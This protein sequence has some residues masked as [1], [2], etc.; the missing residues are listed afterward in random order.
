MPHLNELIDLTSSAPAL[1]GFAEDVRTGL[2]ATP[3]RLSC[4]FFYDVY[5][6]KIFE[7]ICALP[8][9]YLTRAEQEILEANAGEIAARFQGD[10]T[11]L[12]LG[13]GSARKTRVLIEALIEQQ[14][15]LQFVPIDI[16]PTILEQSSRDLQEY[17]PNLEV[18]PVAAEYREGL[19]RAHQL[20][21]G[22]KLIL[23]LGSNIGNFGRGEAALL[24]E[25]IKQYMSANDRLLVG[26]DLRKDKNVLEAAYDD[27]QGVTARFNLNILNRINRDLG[28]T[29]DS[30]RFRHEAIYNEEEG[31]VEMYLV[32]DTMQVV[33]IA[34]LDC[35]VRFDQDERIHTE[36]S[37]KYSLAEI[38]QLARSAGLR[39]QEQSFDERHRFSL[40]LLAIANA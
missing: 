4:R 26:I 1:D 12:E 19:A 39:I 24:I 13:S 33:H 15:Y 36:N 2:S 10:V 31:R 6:S 14:E 25:S 21:S 30:K 29:F 34:D 40:N 22:P 5:G 16:S 23:W 11:L 28:G 37:Y 27:V 17:Y 7:E 35:T 20:V 3:K 32:S 9:Y 38:E 18:N 8:E